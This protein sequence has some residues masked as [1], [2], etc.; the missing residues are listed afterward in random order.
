MKATLVEQ[1]SRD[2]CV[3]EE[4]PKVSHS[5]FFSYC[6]QFGLSRILTFLTR[7]LCGKNDG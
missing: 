7:G 1:A 5:L 4:T 6:D 3:I 2:E